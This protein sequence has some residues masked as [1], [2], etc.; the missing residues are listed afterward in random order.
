MKT[1]KQYFCIII[2]NIALQNTREK[3][4]ESIISIHVLWRIA[5]N[6]AALKIYKAIHEEKQK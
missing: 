1:A 6:A 5:I 2:N 3:Q 4:T